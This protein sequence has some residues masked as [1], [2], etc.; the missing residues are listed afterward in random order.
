LPAPVANDNTVYVV[1]VP[2]NSFLSACGAGTSALGCN[3]PGGLTVAP[4][5][6]YSAAY[7]FADGGIEF[8]HEVTEAIAGFEGANLTSTSCPNNP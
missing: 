6:Y 7:V 5:T 1:V 2:A 8:P 4:Q 3:F